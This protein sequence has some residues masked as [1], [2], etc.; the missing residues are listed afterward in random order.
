MDRNAA[1]TLIRNYFQS[2]LEQDLD[3]FLSTMTM[4]VRVTEC[5]GPVYVGEEEVRQWFTDWHAGEGNGKVT[6][7]DIQRILFDKNKQMAAV[8]WD[9]EC[10]YQGNQAGFLGA[11]LIHFQEGKISSIQE[12]QMDREQ[13]RPYGDHCGR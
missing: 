13:Y 2:W 1:A 9:F 7:W 6:R 4:D 3:L 12:Y 10:I 8:E 5:Y 11:S